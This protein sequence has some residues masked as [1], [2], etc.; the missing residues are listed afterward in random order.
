[1]YLIYSIIQM[2]TC[3]HVQYAHACC[4]LRIAFLLHMY[5]CMYVY[6]YILLYACM[7]LWTHV[8]IILYVCMHV[9]THSMHLHGNVYVETKIQTL[10]KYVQ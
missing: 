3:M 5:I 1:M 6:V 2:Y 7:H 10:Q 4:M 9:H 8:H